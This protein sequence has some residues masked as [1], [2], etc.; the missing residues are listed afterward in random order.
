MDTE[1]PRS[2]RNW[3]RIVAIIVVVVA[4]GLAA[5]YTWYQYTQQQQHFS[6]SRVVELGDPLVRPELV[7]TGLKSPTGIVAAFDQRL[8]VLEQ[9]GQV[10]IIDNAKK[11]SEKPFLD[12]SSEVLSGGEMGLL[13]LAFHPAY[14]DNGYFYASYIDKDQNT[15]IAR[16]TVSADANVADPASKKVIFTL[17]QP[18][19]NHNGGDIAFG[20]DG[21]LYIALGDGGSGG[22]PHNYGQNKDSYLGKILRIDSNNGDPYAVPSTNPF[23]NEPGVKPEIWAY[24]LRNPWRIS[25]DKE[26]GDLYIADVGQGKLEEINVQKADSKGGENYGW[27][28]YEGTQAHK[29][30]GCKPAEEYTAP[31]VEYNHDD[32]RCSVT[33]GYVY[34]GEQYPA[35]SGKYFYGDFCNGQLFYADTTG[36]T[37]TNVLA[38]TTPYRISTFG[39]GIDGELYFADFTSGSIYHIRDA[40]N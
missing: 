34:R 24:G 5:W 18:Y 1:P 23:V 2:K 16:F 3:S 7:A 14:Q 27:R 22:D 4:M 19:A 9:A 8:F 11:L 35:L 17:K 38:A 26:T 33:G 25:F 6:S 39:Q 29:P 12:L 32:G 20:P 31:I 21:F 28:C 36:D 30:E 15:V 10:R 40:A 13:G 37:W